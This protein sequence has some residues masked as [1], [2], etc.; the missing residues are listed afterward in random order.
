MRERGYEFRLN[1]IRTS[2]VR[3][4]APKGCFAQVQRSDVHLQRVMIAIQCNKVKIMH[5]KART[6]SRNVQ[7]LTVT[8]KAHHLRENNLHAQ[9]FRRERKPGLTNPPIIGT[10]AASMLCH[11]WHLHS[12]Q[13]TPSPKRRLL[14]TL[15][16]NGLE[17][18]EVSGVQGI[19]S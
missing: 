3:L 9:N 6:R 11:I 14:V 13:K 2:R 15:N 10:H 12:L 7:S 4:A 19:A 1:L 5:R 18:L 8:E 17:T 16:V